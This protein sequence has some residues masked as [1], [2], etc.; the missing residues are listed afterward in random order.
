[1]ENVRNLEE[2]TLETQEHRETMETRRNRRDDDKDPGSASSA[3]QQMSDVLSSCMA[4][5][6]GELDTLAGEEMVKAGPVH[7]SDMAAY[8]NQCR[9]RDE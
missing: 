3:A 4:S 2:K 1:M 9:W 8:D 7:L 5:G 6:S